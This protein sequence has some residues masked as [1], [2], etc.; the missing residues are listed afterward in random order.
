[1]LNQHSHPYG[2]LYSVS[3][4]DYSA[5]RHEEKDDFDW[6]AYEAQFKSASLFKIAFD[7]LKGYA[8]RLGL[9]SLSNY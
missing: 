2:L 7:L 5:L 8:V 9:I 1:M 3:P 6:D 4:K